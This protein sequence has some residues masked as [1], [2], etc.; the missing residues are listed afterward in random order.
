MLTVDCPDGGREVLK[1]PALG[2]FEIK[3]GCTARSTEWIFPASMQ[4]RTEVAIPVGQRTLPPLKVRHGYETATELGKAVSL[5]TESKADLDQLS[6][7]IRRNGLAAG[8]NELTAEQLQKL[9]DRERAKSSYTHYP[10][11]WIL[12]VV[13]VLMFIGWRWYKSRQIKQRAAVLEQRITA[14]ELLEEEARERLD[15]Q[16]AGEEEANARR[17]RV[18]AAAAA[19]M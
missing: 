8:A 18:E 9:L 13:G 10:F 17:Q 2:V 4:G 5:A 15:Q 11:E 1:V 6:E 19:E 3:K 12:T 7:I 16:D 14:H